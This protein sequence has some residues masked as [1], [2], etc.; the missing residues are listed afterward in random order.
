M[1]KLLFYFNT[2][3][4]LNG[5]FLIF[6]RTKEAVFIGSNFS[7]NHSKL[8]DKII[9]TNNPIHDEG[10]VE[11]INSCRNRTMLDTQVS[12]KSFENIVPAEDPSSSRVDS[13]KKNCIREDGPAQEQDGGIQGNNVSNDI[14]FDGPSCRDAV[15]GKAVNRPKN[16]SDELNQSIAAERLGLTDGILNR[17]SPFDEPPSSYSFSLKINKIQDRSDEDIIRIKNQ[18]ESTRN[19]LS[20]LVG[21]ALE[22]SKPL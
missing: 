16:R 6:Y 19:N 10:N 5:Y 3:F 18:V 1:L 12:N 9:R 22:K 4:L 13:T 17:G 8:V 21:R 2:V 15:E 7:E 14:L 11:N 20:K